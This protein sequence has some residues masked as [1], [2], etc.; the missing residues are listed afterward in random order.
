MMAPE[1]SGGGAQGGAPN[2]S[3]QPDSG[4]SNARNGR[5][6]RH[7]QQNRNTPVKTKFEGRCPDLK[8][9]V[10]DCASDTQSDQFTRTLKEVADYV[11]RTYKYG[12]AVRRAVESLEEQ[13][14][15]LPP[16]P[17]DGATFGEQRLWEKAVDEVAKKQGLYEQ[18][19][20]TLFALVWGQCSDALRE[21]LRS[22]TE[23]E[24]IN[25]MQNGLE[26][27]RLMRT[28][29]FNHESTKFVAQSMVENKG[30]VWKCIQEA[31]E[32][33]QAYMDRFINTVAVVEQTGG[34]LGGDPAIERFIAEEQGFNYDA[35]PGDVEAMNDDQ[36]AGVRRDAKELFL[37]TIFLMNAD[38]RRY[39]ELQIVTQNDYTR[40]HNN[41]PRTLVAAY[42]LINGYTSMYRGPSLPR[43][44]DGVSFHNSGESGGSENAAGTVN[45][46]AGGKA[47]VKCRKC[48]E[49]GH[50][51]RECPNGEGGTG[52][53]KVKEATNSGTSN[54]EGDGG[55]GSKGVTFVTGGEHGWVLHEGNPMP[56]TWVLLDNQSTLD[57]FSNP[58]LLENIREGL[59]SMI[60]HCNAGSTKTTLI[61]DLPGYGT[62][63]YNPEG[64]ANIL[65]V[66][67]VV[68]RGYKVTY[69]SQ[70]GNEFLLK[71]PDGSEVEFKQSEQ[72]LFYIDMATK[73]S[74]FVNTVADNKSRYTRREIARADLARR[75][76][77]MIG[78]PSTHDYINIVN[79]NLLL[80]CPVTAA[81][82][83][84]AEEIYGPDIGSLKGKTVRRK[85]DHVEADATTVPC[86]ILT[87]YKNV[88][89]CADV[90]KVN[91]IPF[92]VTIS[93]G[94]RF[95]TAEMIERTSATVVLRAVQQVQQ[96]Y[97]KRGFKLDT[98]VL[99]GEFESLRPKLAE[100]AITLNVTSRDEHVPEAER[101]IRVLK[102]RVRAVWNTLPF[103]RMPARM[104]IELI[105][106]CNFWLN[107]FPAA[108][109][110]S[111]TLSPRAII[112]GT[113]I[114]YRRHCKLQFGEYVQ[115]HEPHDNTMV[116]RTIGAIAL[117]PT[118]NDQG[119]HFFYSLSTGKRINRSRWTTLPMPND[120]VD[121]VHRLARRDRMV[122]GKLSF[123]SRYDDDMDE[124]GTG[125]DVHLGV[126]PIT[127]TDHDD[128]DDESDSDFEPDN[129]STAPDEESNASDEDTDDED[130]TDPNIAE[131]ND[132][133]SVSSDS[134]SS[135]EGND[136]SLEDEA[137]SI[138][139]NA[140]QNQGV[141]QAEENDGHNQGVG[142]E[143]EDDM[144]SHGADLPEEGVGNIGAEMDQAYGLRT[145]SY[146]LR[147]RR[148]RSYDHLYPDSVFS[149]W[150]FSQH[151]MKAG[152][153]LFGERGTEAVLKELKQL[154]DRQVM[155]PKE[156][157][158]LTREDRYQA[159]SYLMFLKEK[160]DGAIKGRG[161]ADGRKQRA[162]ISKE[163]ASSPTVSTEA[164]LLTSVIDAR[165]HRDVATVDVPGA[166]M[167]AD[168]DDVVYMRL[169]G[170]MVDLLV[171]IDESYTQ[172]VT[173][174]K[175]KRVIYVQLVK[176][177][178]GTLKAAML[179]WKKLT[180]ILESW[181]FVTNKYDSCVAN[182]VI[183]G[184]QCTIAWHVD[185]LK[186]SHVD[187]AV[188]SS[189]IDQLS[190][191]FGKEA[192]LT[193]N[194]GKVH[195]YLG[196]TLD[197]SV[198]GKVKVGMIQ[199]VK[200]MLAELHDDMD[201]ESPNAAAAHLFDVN[202]ACPKLEKDR[203]EYFHHHV[204][205]LL[206][207]CKRARPDI[208]PAVAFLSTRVQAPDE[209][210]YK[211]LA[212]VMR[213]LRA[214]I[215]MELTLEGDGMNVVKWWADASFAVHP[216]FKS[217]TGGAMSMGKGVI[218]G[219][220]TRQKI[221]TR[222]STEA[223]LVAANDVMAQLLWTQN[224]LRDQGYS[225]TETRLYQDNQS[226]ILLEKNGRGSSSKRTRHLNIRYFF[227]TDRVA[228][229]DLT[230]EY[231]PTEQMIADF[232][233]KP[234]QGS[235]FRR[236]R[237][238]VMNVDPEQPAAPDQRSVLQIN[239]GATSVGGID[240]GNHGDW[241]MVTR[242][243]R[244]LKVIQANRR[245]RDVTQVR[246]RKRSKVSN[247][248]ASFDREK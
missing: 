84:A 95:G 114:D 229:K 150:T 29:A 14:F 206:F 164:V 2:G 47:N 78:R 45:A 244:K 70:D 154:H 186:I 3:P 137:Q 106:C 230:I 24:R 245:G 111:D 233:T 116:P 221:N 69:N 237:D 59:G 97:A 224:F 99:D 194:R 207:L 131:P 30:K 134:S 235:L 89:V 225:S 87:R 39:K 159:L 228:N 38:R 120:V 203:A 107:C 108:D 34:E 101:R 103:E 15:D 151:S 67:R 187:S 223:E 162:Y 142:E 21:K 115:T 136:D 71:G 199:Y 33:N 145:S 188:V 32:S 184:K 139:D 246:T 216:D 1:G 241:S 20:M 191:E 155:V 81:D 23:Y 135:D 12:G 27:L 88:T 234:L 118:G 86:S 210:D 204:A 157:S 48:K 171:Q 117:R 28:V 79:K 243:R 156:A 61:G 75:L 80:N 211:K 50:Y 238:L 16:D 4:G 73:G 100:M 209:D 219:T 146:R 64:I 105:Y 140:G 165:E 176:A 189:V 179:F 85:V 51:E 240:D 125:P 144:D 214:T 17:P 178:Y 98:L 93:R 239:H 83:R 200:N 122:K 173:I 160:R 212:R 76:Q 183:N 109:G 8:G 168:M 37:A 147:D 218:Y 7:N 42:E 68:D 25:T 153:K 56:N 96:I 49:L 55:K 197:F 13:T 163:E 213:Y 35:A 220:S 130:V 180:G 222:S 9:H 62:V 174:E 110:I 102:E 43:G 77:Q 40:G 57:V 112:D 36:A 5:K 198:K 236:L 158:S 82:I 74:I 54:A 123:V 90:M 91:G 63:W 152:L 185:D 132:D 226:A 53:A 31:H 232:F 18:N 192:P 92:L 190:G 138:A 133:R 19:L 124:L 196:M 242:R 143:S 113:N 215:N 41:Y 11:G 128:S 161:C 193:V 65:S 195:D 202:E 121:R 148:P 172:F 247:G 126:E 58:D 149:Q 201:G 94:I 169:E 182:K 119:G 72:G 52:T 231:C 141:P 60:I 167:Q 6:Q 26:L 208:Q 227:I 248:D 205:K 175:G 22:K 66:A 170:V 46:N 10:F 129:E 127:L 217:H 181:G 44:N 104:I 166:F 177:L